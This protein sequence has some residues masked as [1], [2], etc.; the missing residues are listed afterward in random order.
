MSNLV[1]A[2]LV[3]F[4]FSVRTPD[5]KGV[6]FDWEAMAGAQGKNSV[7]EYMTE[8]E[9]GEREYGVRLKQ[10]WGMWGTWS[11]SGRYIAFSSLGRAGS[12]QEGDRLTSS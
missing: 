7:V 3:F 2:S 10:A 12:W 5:N 9:D 4:S 8:R 11:P 1:L 6:P